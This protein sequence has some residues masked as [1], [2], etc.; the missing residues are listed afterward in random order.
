MLDDFV[1]T[2]GN[3]EVVQFSG[4]NPPS[5]ESIDFVKARSC[6]WDFLLLC[7]HQW[8][9]IAHDEPFL[10]Q[11]AEVAPFDLFPIRGYLTARHTASSRRARHP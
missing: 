2:E 6:A 3:P 10:E 8:K 7:Q 1:R 4:A 9:R 5:I 11:L